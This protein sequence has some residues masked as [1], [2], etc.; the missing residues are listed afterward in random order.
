MGG[1]NKRAESGRR[2]GRGAKVREASVGRLVT[3]AS[4]K[5]KR[6]EETAKCISFKASPA[7]SWTR[8]GSGR[9]ASL[10]VV[11]LSIGTLCLCSCFLFGGFAGYY[12]ERRNGFSLACT[13]AGESVPCAEKG[14]TMNKKERRVPKMTRANRQ[15]IS[16]NKQ[17]S[18]A[19]AVFVFTGA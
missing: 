7:A 17:T 3:F 8:A 1:E 4:G 15:G 16:A 12:P 2:R 5:S 10:A 19:L 18:Q 13:A 9:K 6:M 11:P 14:K